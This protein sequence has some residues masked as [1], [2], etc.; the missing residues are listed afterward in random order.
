[1]AWFCRRVCL[2]A[3][4]LFASFAGA[5]PVQLLSSRDPAVPLPGGGNGNSVAP[6]MTPDGRFVLFASSANNLVPGGNSQFALNLFLRDRA[7]KATVLVSANINGTGGGN[8][9]SMYGQV[10]TNGRYV[11]FQSDASNLL[12]G[13]TNNVTDVFV[14]DLLTG[15]N[16]LVSVAADGGWGNGASTDPVMTPD[17]HYVAFVSDATN[18]VSGD[19]NG[20]VDVFVR[21]LVSGT[22]ILASVGAVKLPPQVYVTSQTVIPLPALAITPDGRRVAFV[23]SA[24]GLAPGVRTTQPQAEVYVRDMVA[25]TTTWASSNAVATAGF[26][27]NVSSIFLSYHPVMGDDGRFIAF[28]TSSFTGLGTA[29]ILQYD[30]SSNT[31]L[32]VTTNALPLAFNDDVYGP[33]MTPDG[34]YVAFSTGLAKT[35]Q[36]PYSNLYFA[37]THAGTN[38]LLNVCQDGTTPTNSAS[39]TP[40]ISPDGRFV[41]FVSSATNLVANTISTGFHIYLRDVQAAA[42]R[43]IDVDTNQVGSV[44]EYGN[45]PSLTADGRF[46]AFASPDGSLVSQDNNQAA[47]VFVRDVVAGTN[48]WISKPAPMSLPVTGN[49]S[50][51]LSQLS[52]TPNG[53]W[54]VF[55]SRAEDLVTND[56]N[57]D[58]DVFMSDLHQGKTTLVSVG[59][60]G[61]SAS[62]GGS[63]SPGIS[64]NGQFVVF[65]STAT[66]LVPNV[67]TSFGDVYRRDLASGSNVLVSVSTDGLNPGNSGCSSP[68]MS[69]GGRFIAFLSTATNLVTPSTGPGPNSFWRDMVSG[70]TIALTTNSA[71]LFPPSMSADGRY[72][73]FSLTPANTVAVWGSQISTNIYTAPGSGVAT[74]AAI[75]PNGARLLYQGVSSLKAVDLAGKTN[76]LSMSSSVS[77]RSPVQ[78][79]AD[80]RFVTFVARSNVVAGPFTNNQVFL[81][82][83][84]AGTVTV[85]SVTP[86]HVSGGNGP[87]DG[88]ALS[89]NGRYV[90]YR[91][92]APDLAPGMTPDSNLLLYDRDTGSNTVL[93][94]GTAGL[95]W[96]SRASNPAID[97]SGRH[98]AFQSCQG[99]VPGD[100]NRMPDIFATQPAVTL[101]SDADGIPDWWMVKY[102]GHPTGLASDHSRALDDAD[103]DGLTNLQ[104]FLT[105]T[106]PTDPNSF[107]HIEASLPA[108]PNVLL[109]WP[110]VSGKLYQIQYKNSLLDPA[111]LNLGNALVATGQGSL[112]VPI[113]QSAAFYRVVAIE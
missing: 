86:G 107:L 50:S 77:V 18:L 90:V 113:T 87:S 101:D 79:S 72:V 65:V 88:P 32:L 47:D 59:M 64:S 12:P 53:R 75:S 100:I 40:V 58:Q 4:V 1:M 81:G 94:A 23:S 60:D 110:A 42:T 108:G 19:T 57:H 46:V 9:S 104:E 102:F 51:W 105:G 76:V 10:S 21:D 109:S 33:E 82:D 2:F 24:S 103:G 28:K 97:A 98:V 7:S 14:R 22:T 85:V 41:A 3:L 52:V 49:G 6:A 36:P 55:S 45:A 62:G 15:S 111:W 31:L 106:D 92:S 25:G 112:S 5:A 83:L 44:D 54:V 69:Q 63:V 29:A 96:S 35:N 61:N 13:D 73:A 37:D 17:G 68:V 95:D 91:S 93:N 20:L 71:A 89:A 34:R 78:W 39:D 48:E 16:I 56:L 43:L 80:G 74:S 26:P 66:N 8:S 38:I 27:T 67:T 30:S 70:V 84:L 99:L 11:V